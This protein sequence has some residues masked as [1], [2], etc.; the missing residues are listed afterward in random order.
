MTRVITITEEKIINKIYLVRGKK[1]MLDFDLAEMYSVETKQLKRQVKRN[2]KR[3]P[4]DFMFVLSVKEYQSLRS[5]IGTLKRGE[6]SKYLPLAFTEQGVAMLSSILNSQTAIRV[7]IQI[8]RVFTKM[9]ELLLTNK[10]ILLRLEQVEKRM[11]KQGNKMKKYEADIQM[12]F[13]VLKQ[14]LTP[15]IKPRPKI[16]FRRNNE[17]E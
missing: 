4:G 12:I 6:H 7:N 17:K 9:R 14:L 2:S 1:I 8:I 15:P 3:F 11:L 5:Q 16:G 10:N 13:Q